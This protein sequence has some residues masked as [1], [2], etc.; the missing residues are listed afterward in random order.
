MPLYAF[1]SWTYNNGNPSSN[2]SGS[3]D[4]G[5]V[6]E[7]IQ[8]DTGR[9]VIKSED[10]EKFKEALADGRLLAH[11]EHHVYSEKVIYTFSQM[12]GRIQL[13]TADP[14]CSLYYFLNGGYHR[15]RNTTKVLGL[16]TPP[17]IDHNPLVIGAVAD[18][19]SGIFDLATTLAEVPETLAFFNAGY[20]AIKGRLL[21]LRPKALRQSIERWRRMRAAG[22]RP[23]YSVALIVASE[24][25]AA[26]WLTYRYGLMPIVY[27]SQD[28][29]KAYDY[30]GRGE[31]T[32]DIVEGKRST[33]SSATMSPAVSGNWELAGLPSG[34]G[35][36]G[37]VSQ[38]DCKVDRTVRASA[39]C[40]LKRTF[41]ALHVSP[42][43][44]W[45]VVPLSFVVDWF[46]N[47]A[48]HILAYFPPPTATTFCSYSV[49]DKYESVHRHSWDNSSCG[50]VY[51]DLMGKRE[52]EEYHRRPVELPDLSLDNLTFSGT[53]RLTL[54]RLAD[55]V[56]LMRLLGP[57]VVREIA[58]A[59]IRIG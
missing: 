58:N 40:Q 55:S 15:A 26:A 52:K 24:E 53:E 43:T 4:T 37:Y 54:A 18:A 17:A 30:L 11:T 25:L 48:D 32:Y 49:K 2:L 8:Y 12:S 50:C 46:T 38:N 27:A 59:L 3:I 22:I 9:V 51:T 36:P 16:A 57:S 41:H 6:A 34:H 56:A 31:R 23:S 35:G 10:T 28:L 13:L 33:S 42:I 29:K 21:A 14:G 47:I 7:G 1:N 44:F 5:S 39:Q 45:E 20:Q 19:Q